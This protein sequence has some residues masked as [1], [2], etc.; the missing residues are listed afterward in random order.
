MLTIL[1]I[2]YLV[3]IATEIINIGKNGLNAELYIRCALYGVALVS[4]IIIYKF[5][6]ELKEQ[7]YIVDQNISKISETVE[8]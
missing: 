3:F 6:D 5:A 2:S 8:K 7:S 1:V 4:N